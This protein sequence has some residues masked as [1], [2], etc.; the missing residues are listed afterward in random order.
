[1]E[2]LARHA[3]KDRPLSDEELVKLLKSKDIKSP[4]LLVSPPSG[5]APLTV[6]V[7]WFLLSDDNPAQIEI[8]LEG[9]ETFKPVGVGFDPQSGIQNGKLRHIYEREGTFQVTLRVHDNAGGVTTHAKQVVAMSK[10]A[11]ETSLERSD[12]TS[13]LECVHSSVRDAYQKLLPEVLKS[14]TPINQILSASALSGCLDQAP[15]L[16]W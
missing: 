5:P 13:A 8:D 3:P 14:G 9:N 1:M 7:G 11:F 15:S 4:P 10:A 2:Q 12:I 6:T 16:K